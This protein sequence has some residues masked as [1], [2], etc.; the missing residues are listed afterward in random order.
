MNKYSINNP[1]SITKATDFSDNEIN[2][3]WVN[4]NKDYRILNPTELLPKYILGGKGC[5][6]T[7]LLR[8]FSYPLQKIRK[9]ALSAIILEDKYIGI[10]SVLD[11]INSSRFKGKGI[12]DEQWKSAFEYYF[13]LYICDILLSI[14][15]D[16]FTNSLSGK[17]TEKEF[18]ESI[19]SI[20]YEDINNVQ[21]IDE[22]LKE[23]SVL[24]KKIDIEIVNAA[25]NR[26]LDV[27]AMKILFSP[28]DLLF[29]IPVLLHKNI[30]T[31]DNVR[32]VYIL[33]EYEKLFEWQKEFVNTLVWEKKQPCTFWIGA[34][35]YGYTTTRTKTDE[36]IK[37]GSEFQPIFLDEIFQGNDELYKN[38]AKDLYVSRLQRYFSGDL[39]S[40]Q[41]DKQF[42]TKLEK[43]S[44]EKITV[45]LSKRFNGKE[46]KHIIE[47]RSRIKEG[48]H[49]K[50]INHSISIDSIIE[51]I[52]DGTNDNPLEQKYKIYLL[53]REWA[54]WGMQKSKITEGKKKTTKVNIE[55]I[56]DYVN[57]Q[58]SLYKNGEKGEFDNI[59]EKYKADLL[60]QL[61]YENNIK[62]TCYS[63]IEEFINLSW[64]NPRVF[65]LIL[66]LIVE[67]SDLLGEKPL[68]EGSMI[69]LEAQY[70]G[71]FE[72]AKWF[73]QDV[74]IV[75]ESGKNLY[76][77]LN[78]LSSVFQVYRFSD[79]P[80]ETSVCAFNFGI[81]DI[82]DNAIKYIK[83]A[84]THS[85]IVEV[86]DRKQRNSGRKELNYQLNRIL[87]PLWNLPSSRRG[88]ADLSSN[89]IN[90]IFDPC[91]YNTF[92][93][94]YKELK[95]RFSAPLFGKNKKKQDSS[96]TLN[97]FH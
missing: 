81:E 69:T 63:G 24:R 12:D 8:Y 66:K 21:T 64:G 53:Y 73:Y 25:F 23:L 22:L 34:R 13:E 39:T 6:K 48:S 46:Y 80:T 85:L 29:G 31:L 7:H 91:K 77:S 16:I 76:K 72:T 86:K 49:E 19:A 65:L 71:V 96:N 2:E 37:P 84:K 17:Y 1:F 67:K 42:S 41:I 36:Q 40:E 45:E 52:I 90:A 88:G 70:Q 62:N 74:E 59:K 97:L 55:C 92:S 83:L 57:E 18:V 15:K 38:F 54:N 61:T 87:A 33:D 9:N 20:F 51:K 60:A 56:I 10:Y 28:G 47:L 4:V 68:E 26:R 79:K 35:R 95:A 58:Y 94:E 50:V 11:G 44:D 93:S 14:A 89:M 82:S 78:S 43:Y 5:G 30:K 32:F 27:S 3:Y 75:G